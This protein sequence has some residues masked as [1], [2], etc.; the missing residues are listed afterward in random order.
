MQALR[1]HEQRGATRAWTVTKLLGTVAR[2][3]DERVRARALL[4]GLVAEGLAW[5]DGRRCGL[6]AAPI[7]KRKLT[8][9][10]KRGV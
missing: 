9:V 1:G 6:G 8:P 7:R 10:R 2:T 5:V 3:K 4:G